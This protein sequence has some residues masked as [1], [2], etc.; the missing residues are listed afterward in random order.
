MT[1]AVHLGST[2]TRVIKWMSSR[3][4][5]AVEDCFS[6]LWFGTMVMQVW[7]TRNILYR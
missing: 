5:E 1:D 2:D 4:V 3:A 7:I 6:A